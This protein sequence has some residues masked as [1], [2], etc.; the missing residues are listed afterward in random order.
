MHTG[1]ASQERADVQDQIATH[2]RPGSRAL[3]VIVGDW[4]FVRE[5]RDRLHFD[6]ESWTGGEDEQEHDDFAEA[7]SSHAGSSRS[8]SR[9]LLT[10]LGKELR[11]WT[12]HT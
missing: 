3:T 12:G 11:G 8:G 4:N 2:I 9:S 1:Q 7:S 10:A 6:S 5:I